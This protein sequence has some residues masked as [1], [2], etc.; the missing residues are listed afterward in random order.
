MFD[1]IRGLKKPGMV[2]TSPRLVLYADSLLR[3]DPCVKVIGLS[4]SKESV[5][6][7]MTEAGGT[8]HDLLARSMGRVAIRSARH[9]HD[10]EHWLAVEE[11]VATRYV[12]EYL[13]IMERLR[14]KHP[15][16]FLAVS[17]DDLINDPSVQSSAKE[18]VGFA[19]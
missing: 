11:E 19:V 17:M 4:V 7:A 3:L 16:R 18:F 6:A 15:Q 14:D 12:L 13:D 1:Y 5:V 10:V 9:S 8:P 2:I